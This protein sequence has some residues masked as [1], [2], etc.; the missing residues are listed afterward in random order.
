MNL[1][2]PLLIWVVFFFFT[3]VIAVEQATTVTTTNDYAN[4]GEPCTKI[5]E[6][7]H[8]AYLTC[9]NGS[10]QCALQSMKFDD[11]SSSC[12]MIPGEKCIY[13][14]AEMSIGMA[15]LD[16]SSEER[17]I[18]DRIS[19]RCVSNAACED[20]FCTCDSGYFAT[21]NGTCERQHEY[22]EMCTSDN[23]CR[24]SLHLICN[25]DGKCGCNE[26]N[27][28]FDVAHGLCVGLPGSSCFDFELCAANAYCPSFG[29]F[30]QYDVKCTCKN[31]YFETA[32]RTCEPKQGSRA[33]CS[34]N[35]ECRDD[36]NLVCDPKWKVC[37]C[38][39][40]THI[41]EAV[42]VQGCLALVGSSCNEN[43][44]C[45]PHADC[46]HSGFL[47]GNV[48]ARNNICKCGYG[49]FEGKNKTCDKK[50]EYDGD[51]VDDSNCREDL[52][53][54][55]NKITNRCTCNESS[56]TF[57]RSRKRCLSLAGTTCERNE[58]CVINSI[59]R[60]PGYLYPRHS[61]KAVCT[62]KDGF[63]KSADGFC[64]GIYGSKCE[65]W[66]NSCKSD[67]TCRNGECTCK[68]QQYYDYTREACVTYL[69]A[70]C[71]NESTTCV[72]NAQCTKR[73]GS[74]DL[75]CACNPGTVPM[76]GNKKCVSLVGEKC[77][78]GE[79][80]YL[81]CV[82][83]AKCV[84]GYCKCSLDYFTT[85]ATCERKRGYS[86]KCTVSESCEDNF[87]D[88]NGHCGCNSTTSLYD[89]IKRTCV[90]LANA[91]C[92]DLRDCVPNAVCRSHGRLN[93]VD[94]D[95]VCICKEG[96]FESANGTCEWKRHF[97]EACTESKQCQDVSDLI[98]SVHGRCECNV[99][100]STFDETRRTCL[101]LHGSSCSSNQHCVPNAKCRNPMYFVHFDNF[102]PHAKCECEK[103]LGYTNSTDG[104]CI[105][106]YY[107]GSCDNSQ[108]CSSKFICEEGKCVCQYEDH[109]IYDYKTRNCISLIKGPC[110]NSTNLCVKNAHCINTEDG[111]AECRCKQGFIGVDRRCE[112]TFGQLCFHKN[113]RN[114]S[115]EETIDVCDRISPLKCV[116][117]TC[118]CGGFQFYDYELKKCR[119]LV[120]SRCDPEKKDFCTEGATCEAY[121]GLATKRYGR[122]NCM[123]GYFADDN[124]SCTAIL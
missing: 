5:S 101:R 18:R 20:G 74:S 41:Y 11:A 9:I 15:V 43:Q 111:V 108:S 107:G 13:K 114:T 85:N 57:D 58:H 63:G 14:G 47:N 36:L 115:N 92:Y 90:R 71:T 50:G 88:K 49:Y 106:D 124:R 34:S 37:A 10:C 80:S 64:L 104:R 1:N 17:N 83:H 109:Q 46:T 69:N 16:P 56:H 3:S 62:C 77:S 98:C 8:S 2:T 70:P 76:D 87:C 29:I 53:L 42:L 121:R 86:Q 22:G 44:N 27:S 33:P 119:G 4:Y 91:K 97:G 75:V 112:L 93:P 39:E 110:D 59:C 79:T 99:T 52:K 6:C 68:A 23:S 66:T 118:Q 32:N 105:I 113:S 12:W 25:S 78:E 60:S 7:D 30:N 40:T 103:D 95:A 19:F 116:H 102:S 61:P 84:A 67:L 35:H 55:C 31:G 24:S 72:A 117:G 73:E 65:S 120:G 48:L 94:E 89:P 54:M 21:V 122:C 123:K 26:T 28:E 100:I 81:P 38:N 96:Y 51:C 45:V 82:P